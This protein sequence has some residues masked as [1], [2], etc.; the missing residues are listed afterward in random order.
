MWENGRRLPSTCCNSIRS[1]LDRGVCHHRKRMDGHLATP[2]LLLF[3]YNQPRRTKLSQ[4][5]QWSVRHTFRRAHRFV[6]GRPRLVDQPCSTISSSSMSKALAA[7][8]YRGFEGL[9]RSFQL[10]VRNPFRPDPDG[11]AI[12]PDCLSRQSAALPLASRRKQSTSR[13]GERPGPQ[14]SRAGSR[15]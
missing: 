4:G 15:R 3:N 12:D 7:L 1:A 13:P 10:P 6:A 2:A 8:D 14:R 11:S 9:N 5:R